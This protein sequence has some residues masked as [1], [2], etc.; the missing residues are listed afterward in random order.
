MKPGYILIDFA[1]YLGT[2]RK[3][4]ALDRRHLFSD[5]P[6]VFIFDLFIVRRLKTH[7]S[8]RGPSLPRLPRL[9]TRVQAGP[10][11]KLKEAQGPTSDCGPSSTKKQFFVFI[12][13]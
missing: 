12:P 13:A 9:E 7:G 8:E 11:L 4:M 6:F 5:Q 10:V 3:Y 2:I 1:F